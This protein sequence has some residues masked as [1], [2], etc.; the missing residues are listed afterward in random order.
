[1]D[2]SC[3][4]FSLRINGAIESTISSD[5]PLERTSTSAQHQREY[6]RSEAHLEYICEASHEFETIFSITEHST[7]LLLLLP[8]Q[9]LGKPFAQDTD[10]LTLIIPDP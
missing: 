10:I 4:S 2:I 8:P 1:M 5:E 3:V 7:Q 6:K 9:L